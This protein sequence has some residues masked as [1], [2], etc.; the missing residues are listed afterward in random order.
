MAE[1]ARE[2]RVDRTTIWRRYLAHLESQ[3]TDKK[4]EL[5]QVQSA[6]ESLG[7]EFQRKKAALVA[8]FGKDEQELKSRLQLLEKKLASLSAEYA[9]KRT[10]EEQKLAGALKGSRE[11]L[12]KTQNQVDEL[13]KSTSQ[14]GLGLDEALGLLAEI[15]DLGGKVP[16][17]QREL[18]ELSREI[19]DAQVL[20]TKL[21][22]DVGALKSQLSAG[23]V[24]IASMQSSYTAL[25]NWNVCERPQLENYRGWLESAV[26]KLEVKKRDGI[27][28]AGQLD[29]EIGA[30]EKVNGMLNA[31]LEKVRVDLN[32]TVEK[33]ELS[34]VQVQAILTSASLEAE[35][36]L[37]DSKVRSEEILRGAI[38]RKEELEREVSKLEGEIAELQKRREDLEVEYEKKMGIVERRLN[39]I[40]EAWAQ[41]ARVAEAKGR[42]WPSLGI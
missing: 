27:K 16:A 12:A 14:H 4:H 42:I 24:V 3:A 8:A 23:R 18:T 7:S 10:S 33:L 32:E 2:L 31:A 9:R 20:K 35:R 25:S 6:I 39:E 41:M 15:K 17:K 1:I 13:R 28:R 30:K 22:G 21:R 38:L 34:R 19:R 11:E 40:R 36:I 37:G 29:R 5:I 26:A